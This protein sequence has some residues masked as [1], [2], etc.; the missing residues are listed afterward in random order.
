MASSEVRKAVEEKDIDA[1]FRGVQTLN[2]LQSCVAFKHFASL[3]E[4]KVKELRKNHARLTCVELTGLLY[5][6]SP[7]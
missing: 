5:F 3:R 1:F 7:A 6:D 4:I 2:Y